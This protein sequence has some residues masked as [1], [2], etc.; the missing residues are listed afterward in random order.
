[1]ETVAIIIKMPCHLKKAAE[2][3][4]ARRGITVSALVKNYLANFLPAQIE[5]PIS[6][7]AE[8]QP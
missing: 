1:M 3:E 2:T 7:N 6:G 5:K 4:A 8:A